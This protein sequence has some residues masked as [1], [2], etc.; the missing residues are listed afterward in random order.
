M[1]HVNDRDCGA[2]QYPPHVVL[3]TICYAFCLGIFTS[4]D[5]ERQTIDSLSFQYITG[6]RI[7]DHATI[8]RFFVNNRVAINKF[9]GEILVTAADLGFLDLTNLG[10]DGTK[11][12]ANANINR[13]MTVAE[14]MTWL[15][16]Y[17]TKIEAFKQETN[18]VLT[19][20]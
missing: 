19:P 12:K 8:C 18:N 10:M 2:R 6:R 1:F 7:I 17:E 15:A 4:R 20:N 5:I 14:A 13:S 16:D 9:F 11:I 3:A